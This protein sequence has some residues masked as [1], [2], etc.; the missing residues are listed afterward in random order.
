MRKRIICLMLA[1]VLLCGLF[2][3]HSSETEGIQ[4]GVEFFY[5]RKADNYVY[6]AQDGV[7]AAEI[8]EASGRTDDLAEL[9]SM[10][11]RGPM[12]ENLRSPFP[13]GCT[14]EK[15]RT[16]DDTIFV[17]LSEEFTA[18]ENLELTLACASLAKT[19]FSLSDLPKVRI[20][21]KSDA[22]NIAI[23]LDESDLAFADYSAFESQQK[24]EA[25]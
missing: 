20:E 12:D 3:C 11:L 19:C 8:W 4:E 2:G 21:A 17:T 24:T 25:P 15:V 9:L 16:N 10:Y 1:L 18:L 7:L 14:L 23:T 6:G 5:P 22:R 13:A